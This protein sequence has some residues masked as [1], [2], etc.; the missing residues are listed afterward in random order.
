LCAI[1]LVKGGHDADEEKKKQPAQLDGNLSHRL[2]EL[3]KLSGMPI[4]TVI[5]RAVKAWLDGD[6]KRIAAVMEPKR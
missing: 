1:A 4:E 3:S 2:R 6:G 5:E